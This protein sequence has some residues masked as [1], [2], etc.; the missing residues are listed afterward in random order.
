M[1][2]II[3]KNG[4]EAQGAADPKKRIR[5]KRRGGSHEVRDLDMAARYSLSLSG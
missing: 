1:K 5:I 3:G 2:R 4:G